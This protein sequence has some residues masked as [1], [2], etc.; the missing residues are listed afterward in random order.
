MEKWV[1]SPFH[2]QIY[3]IASVEKIKHQKNKKQTNKNIEI[4]AT[5]KKL[6]AYFLL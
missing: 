1:H 2:G 3:C 4:T 5:M 6:A